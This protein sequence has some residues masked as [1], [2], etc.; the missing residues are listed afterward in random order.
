MRGEGKRFEEERGRDTKRVKK[1]QFME[2][3][4]DVFVSGGGRGV[5]A[6]QESTGKEHGEESRGRFGL[7][8]TR[9]N[10]KQSRGN[11]PG[12]KKKS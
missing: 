3:E 8:K 11:S 2:K 12:P 7:C 1:K 10:R 5:H 9:Q 6:Q 4:G